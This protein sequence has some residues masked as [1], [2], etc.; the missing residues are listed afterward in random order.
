MF[1]RVVALGTA[2]LLAACSVGPNYEAPKIAA[3]D[4]WKEDASAAALWPSA[5]WWQGFESA[6][7]DRLITNAI[8]NNHDLAAA[9]NR[10]AE[11]EAQAKIA[12]A[13][14]YPSLAAGAGVTHAQQPGNLRNSNLSFGSS[15]RGPQTTYSAS[16]TAAYEVDLWGKNQ[17]AAEAAATR[18]RSSQFDQETVAI[19]L[20]SGLAPPY[21]HVL[22]LRDRV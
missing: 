8:A 10:V 9:V 13:P 22:S 14:L 11:S 1:R 21:F 2:A 7:L 16:L 18:V 3:P 20:M 15:S 6:E 12:G 19:T 4:A 5:D 17:S